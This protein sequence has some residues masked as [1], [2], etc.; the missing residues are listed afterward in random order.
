MGVKKLGHTIWPSHSMGFSLIPSFV[1]SEHE[2]NL[3]RSLKIGEGYLDRGTQLAID[4]ML[5]SLGRGEG[6]RGRMFH[7]S[8]HPSEKGRGRKWV[9]FMA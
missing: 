8:P 1:P 4:I 3:P 5:I 9:M 6:Q 2:Q 7:T